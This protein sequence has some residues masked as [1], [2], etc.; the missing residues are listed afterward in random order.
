MN[1]IYNTSIMHHLLDVF[2]IQPEP[3]LSPIN[4]TSTFTCTAVS[5]QVQ[6][7]LWEVDGGQTTSELYTEVLRKRGIQW[8]STRD[9]DRG[10]VTQLLT[11]TASIINN[12]T[13]ISCVAFTTNHRFLKTPP[14]TLTVYGRQHCYSCFLHSTK[15]SAMVVIAAC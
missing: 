12:G 7:L 11:A 6:N 15:H 1:P 13:M 2:L 5:G 10:W 14:V 4:S 9:S 8:N 3:R